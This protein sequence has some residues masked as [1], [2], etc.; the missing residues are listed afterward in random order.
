LVGPADADGGVLEDELGVAL[1][2]E[3]ADEVEL[4]LGEF[5]EGFLSARAEDQL[6]DCDRL[7]MLACGLTRDRVRAEA[8]D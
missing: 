8:K 4:A 3:R 6:A 7:V 2:G 5:D 1:G